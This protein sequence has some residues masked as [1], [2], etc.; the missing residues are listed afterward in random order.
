[1]T[2]CADRF[3]GARIMKRLELSDYGMHSH[4]NVR[5]VGSAWSFQGHSIA[6]IQHCL[7]AHR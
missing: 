2:S 3:C 7:E 4:T 1:M 5:D 6:D